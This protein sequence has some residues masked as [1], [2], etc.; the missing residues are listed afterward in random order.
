VFFGFD[1]K[2]YF[3]GKCFL[4]GSICVVFLTFL[5]MILRKVCF[6]FE[7]RKCFQKPFPKEA[8]KSMAS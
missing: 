1:L 3:D 5:L 7:N 6:C 4:P 2:K 8:L